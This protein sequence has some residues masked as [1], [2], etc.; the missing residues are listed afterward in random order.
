MSEVIPERII[1]SICQIIG[2]YFNKVELN[3]ICQYNFL[4][5]FLGNV[6]FIFTSRKKLD[7]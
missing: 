7:C 3:L 1:N 2:Y 6:Q 4:R 5:I